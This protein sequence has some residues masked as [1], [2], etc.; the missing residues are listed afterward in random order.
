LGIELSID[1]QE[2]HRMLR[3]MVPTRYDGPKARYGLPFGAIERPQQPGTDREEAMW[4][5]PGSRWAAALDTA[6]EMGLAIITEAKFGFSCRS[7]L[8]GL[9]LLRS[10]THPDESADK[11]SHHIRFALGRYQGVGDADSPCT[12]AAADAAFVPAPV[13]KG[14]AT[15]LAPFRL[16]DTGS[17]VPSWVLP[18]PEGN[19]YIIRF[20]ETAGRRGACVLDLNEPAKR[21]DYVDFTGKV[22]GAVARTGQHCTIAYVAYQ[23]LS[24]RIRR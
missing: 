10:S 23:V 22:L 12:A 7:G 13:V 21:V 14:S 11:G 15:R 2:T 1:W 6:G 19:G 24:V 8:L 5:V 4:E 18:D 16:G 20:H 17:L 3:Y 9:S